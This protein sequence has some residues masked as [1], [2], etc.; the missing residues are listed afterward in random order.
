MFYS[1]IVSLVGGQEKHEESREYEGEWREDKK[2]RNVQNRAL[3]SVKEGFK[4]SKA[5]QRPKNNFLTPREPVE[6]SWA[7]LT[8]KPVRKN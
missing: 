1:F 7:L 3:H 4:K 5:T 8:L 2:K 6:A